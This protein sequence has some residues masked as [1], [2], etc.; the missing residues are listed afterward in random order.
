MTSRQTVSVEEDRGTPVRCARFHRVPRR[1]GVEGR[2]GE[3]QFIQVDET[4]F[5]N[6]RSST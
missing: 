6:P 3:C 2:W 4:G 5:R 1:A